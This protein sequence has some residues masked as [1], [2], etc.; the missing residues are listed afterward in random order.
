M[1]N[2]IFESACLFTLAAFA[3]AACSIPST[4]VSTPAQNL[5]TPTIVPS[6]IPVDPS[7]TPVEIAA[8]V[9]DDIIPLS[10]YQSSLAR[11]EA[12]QELVGTLLA[13]EDIQTR[14]LD[15]LI[16]RL[17]LAQ[18]ARSSGFTA[19]ETL[20]EQ[21]L[22]TLT[23]QVGGQDAL[24]AWMAANY[25]TPG[26]FREE[27]TLEMEAAWMRDQIAASVPERAEQVLARQVLLN[28]SFEA[29]R[30]Y[31]QLESGA[32]FD[33]IVANNDPQGLGYLGWFPRG[34]LIDQE[35]EEAAFA[36]QPGEYSQVIETRLGFHIVQVLDYD[37]ERELSPDA[38][39]TYQTRQIQAWL[40]EQR[41]QSQIE[42]RV[43]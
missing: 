23:Q 30:L 24:A 32:S 25:Y 38:R 28:T 36:L 35:L 9:N 19:E 10:A 16:A 13:T 41:S 37:P 22:E 3:L 40:E 39:L 33:I 7:P 43:P 18:A 26:S 14:V 4:Q 29:E 17:L 27:L 2:R 34:Y 15:D 42:I 1:K 31:I 8:V 6:P 5:S 20:V 12:A 21:R 11:Y